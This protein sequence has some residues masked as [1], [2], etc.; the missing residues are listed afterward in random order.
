MTVVN[1]N[2]GALIFDY[3]GVLA[4]TEPLHWDSWN[5][6]LAP[7]QIELTWE[8]YCRHCRGVAD[9][10]MRGALIAMSPQA[11]GLPDLAPYLADR[12]REVLKSSLIRTPI[13]A[14]TLE[15][16]RRLGDWRLGLVTSAERDEVEPVLRSANIQ[17]CFEAAVFGGDVPRHKPAPDPYL[18]IAARM[19]ISTGFVFEDS[20]AGMASATAAGF[21]AIR[22]DDPENLP[23]IVYRITGIA[24]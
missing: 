9:T 1:G 2:R 7:F 17:D 20:D 21:S 18:A 11:I 22:V 16:L 5:K 19:S 6:L 3:D 13:S 12:K 4:A 10:R 24:P 8:Q 23:D 15:M 14:S